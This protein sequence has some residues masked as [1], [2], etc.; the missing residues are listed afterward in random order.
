MTCYHVMTCHR[1]TTYHRTT[2][3]PPPTPST[4]LTRGSTPAHRPPMSLNMAF[5]PAST[6]PVPTTDSPPK[7]AR[8]RA[9]PRV[10]ARDPPAHGLPWAVHCCM[11]HTLLDRLYDPRPSIPDS[12]ASRITRTFFSHDHDQ[13]TPGARSDERSHTLS[14]LHPLTICAVHR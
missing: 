1:A 9:S 12:T 4:G 5:P 10:V 6:R 13:H 8:Q 14:S 7:W 3:R 2:A 11:A